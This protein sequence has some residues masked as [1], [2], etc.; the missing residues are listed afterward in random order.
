MTPG[1]NTF[2]RSVGRACQHQRMLVVVL[3]IVMVSSWLQPETVTDEMLETRV[4]DVV[5]R[6][7]ARAGRA[8]SARLRARLVLRGGEADRARAALRGGPGLPPRAAQS[9]LLGARRAVGRRW[10]RWC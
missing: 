5:D 6:L 8:R 9:L 10:R 2:E 7:L 3:V 1:V 4:L